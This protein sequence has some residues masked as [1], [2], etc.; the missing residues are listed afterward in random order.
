[1][2]FG[3]GTITP[4]ITRFEGSEHNFANVCPKYPVRI[5]PMSLKQAYFS[6]VLQEGTQIVRFSLCQF[7]GDP[8]P[9]WKGGL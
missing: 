3:N 4:Q 7:R 8:S 5:S 2:H 6:T 1:M 9:L